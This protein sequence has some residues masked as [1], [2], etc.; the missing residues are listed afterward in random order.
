MGTA[1]WT[2][3]KIGSLGNLRMRIGDVTMSSSYATNGD[4][5]TAGAVEM[6]EILVAEFPETFTGGYELAYDRTNSK[7]KAY[8]ITT[9]VEAANTTNLSG[10]TSRAI[11]WGY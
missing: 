8:V 1:T 5:L 3:K 6:N 10:V 7:V 9:G 4:T 2:S 11:F